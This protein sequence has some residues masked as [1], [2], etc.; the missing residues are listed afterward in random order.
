MMSPGF[1]KKEP[2]GAPHFPQN[3]D[4]GGLLSPQAVHSAG[5]SG[6]VLAIQR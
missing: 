2:K 4:S 1:G 3:F 6:A 5:L